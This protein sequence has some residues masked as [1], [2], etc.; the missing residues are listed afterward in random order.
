MIKP[1]VT[2]V[3]PNYNHAP[4]LER[5][6]KSI[7]GQTY[8]DFEVLLLDDASTDGSRDILRLYAAEH[9]DNTR[10]IINESNSGSPF[11]QWAKGIEA[12]Q[13]ELVWM[14]ES[15]DYCEPDMLGHLVEPFKD[16]EV[17]LSY[18]I[19]LSVDREGT[20]I[21]YQFEDYAAELPL[22]RWRASYVASADEEVTSCLGIRNTVPNASAAL[23]RRS[24]AV[25]YINDPIWQSM[26]ICGDW[27]FYL[28]IIQGGK[29]AFVKEAKSYF[30]HTE[31]NTS[32]REARTKA[33]VNE[34]MLVL[35]TIGIFYPSCPMPVLE[36][37][38][39]F[40]IRHF[41]HFFGENLPEGVRN[42]P[43]TTVARLRRDLQIVQAE[44][45]SVLASRS[46]KFTAWLRACDS[47]LEKLKNRIAPRSIKKE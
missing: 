22:Q 36:K 34:Q 35:A 15:D 12:A 8:D 1:R 4:F 37:N 44:L 13:G 40:L 20:P 25:A 16:P 41:R 24:A 7:Y 27:C 30:T 23:F 47:L 33:L 46:W 31:G 26:R 3:V 38:L 32:A 43:V 19:P 2:V 14:A 29:I 42:H 10:L 11:A 17:V 9:S 5:R 6:L 28:K 39:G 21:S 18:G 45:D